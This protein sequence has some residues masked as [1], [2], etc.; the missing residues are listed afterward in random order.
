MQAQR[1]IPTLDELRAEAA[2]DTGLPPLHFAIHMQDLVQ[3]YDLIQSKTDR[4][5]HVLDGEGKTV[6]YHLTAATRDIRRTNRA[7]SR[8]FR[9]IVT[10]LLQRKPT[11]LCMMRHLKANRRA[12]EERLC[13]QNAERR[14]VMQFFIQ[15]D[16]E[17]R[18]G[19]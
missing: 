1:R 12:R 7:F 5:L 2:D 14:Q 13:P 6:H 4:E 10:G 19:V 3:I 9:S 16:A 8:Q 17:R 15:R 18:E 11:T